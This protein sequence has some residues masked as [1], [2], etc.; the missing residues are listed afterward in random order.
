M[1][2]SYPAEKPVFLF[3]EPE[4]NTHAF[5]DIDTVRTLLA[6][7][8]CLR[9]QLDTHSDALNQLRREHQTLRDQ[10]ASL[11]LDKTDLH[12]RSESTYLNII[13][14]LLS[15]LLGETPAGKR[16]SVFKTQESIAD[17]LI[18]HHPSLM[19]I[20]ERTLQAKF[21]EANRRM[22]NAENARP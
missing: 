9:M 18:A 14:A 4:D 10:F 5:I 19:G 1:H 2:H 8:D 20:N 15:L 12:R 3:G 11:S 13:G 7:R 22:A 16:Y 6:E 21:A 17:A